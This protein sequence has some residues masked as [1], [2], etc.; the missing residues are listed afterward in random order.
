MKIV[1]FS[2]IGQ[3]RSMN[4]D[5]IFYTPAGIGKL[6]NLLVLADGMG[7]EKA[8]DF[9]SRVLVSQ[10]VEAVQTIKGNMTEITL[11][12]KAIEQAN[13]T[14][15]IDS[16]SNDDLE[17]MGSTIVAASVK[18]NRL[19]VANVGDSRLYIL[20]DWTLRQITRDHSYADEM[21]AIGRYEKGSKE[22]QQDKRILT[23]AIGTS[24]NVEIDMFEEDLQDGDVLLLC[25]DG[26]T[27]MV[28]ED[29][30]IA[31]FRRTKSLEGAAKSLIRK[32]NASGGYDNISVILAINEESEADA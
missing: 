17:G 5:T 14:V 30:I 20:R 15:Y 1:G 19:I 12:R 18:N 7:G 13:L 31:T 6:P 23:R 4:Q 27:N 22:Y 9:A 29:E 11:L 10:L 8:G 3:K 25:S 24:A 21:V 28:S 26:L 32:A 2:D 16:K